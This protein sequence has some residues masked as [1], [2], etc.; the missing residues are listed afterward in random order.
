MLIATPPS[1]ATT[2]SSNDSAIGSTPIIFD[3]IKGIL[4]DKKEK[5]TLQLLEYLLSTEK[6]CYGKSNADFENYQLN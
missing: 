2:S 6:M 4:E 1:L 5:E 3:I